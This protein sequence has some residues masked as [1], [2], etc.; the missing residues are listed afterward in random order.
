[1]QMSYFEKKTDWPSFL[2]YW[3]YKPYTLRL[4]NFPRSINTLFHI[5]VELLVIELR[6]IKYTLKRDVVF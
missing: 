3:D 4:L 1:M 6:K 5:K 2:K